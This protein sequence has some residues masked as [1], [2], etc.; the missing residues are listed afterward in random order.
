[1]PIAE[2]ITRYSV[3]VLRANLHPGT[4]QMRLTLELGS[5]ASITF[6]TNLPANV[7]TFSGPNTS[8]FM[9]P[10]QFADAYRVLQTES[11]VF[12]TALDLFGIQVASVHTELD[13]ALGETPGEGGLDPDSLEALVVRA[14]QAGR[15]RD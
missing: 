1:M 12:F 7:V 10:D 5:T 2:R 11:P 8:A 14:R 6:T 9:P 13:L 4:R 3:S 15:D